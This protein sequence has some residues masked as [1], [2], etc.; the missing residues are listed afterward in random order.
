MFTKVILK[1]LPQKK[2]F[3]ER[4]DPRA[5]GAH[6]TLVLVKRTQ[7]TRVDPLYLI[8]VISVL[9]PCK[10]DAKGNRIHYDLNSAIDYKGLT[11]LT[12][13]PSTKIFLLYLLF[14]RALAAPFFRGFRGP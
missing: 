5:Q 12:S 3:S 9:L 14:L 4:R 2:K 10:S 1:I 8:F 13:F 6:G 11:N 7:P